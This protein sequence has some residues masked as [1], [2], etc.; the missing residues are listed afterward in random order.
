MCLNT[1]EFQHTKDDS[2][3]HSSICQGLE[4]VSTLLHPVQ[5]FNY[6]YLH[7]CT[8]RDSTSNQSHIL[9]P[10]TKTHRNHTK[11]S[12]IYINLSYRISILKC[13]VSRSNLTNYS[14]N[15]REYPTQQ[16]KLHT[17]FFIAFLSKYYIYIST[18]MTVKSSLCSMSTIV[19]KVSSKSNQLRALGKKPN[20][21]HVADHSY[22]SKLTSQNRPP[23]ERIHRKS[24]FCRK[25]FIV[26]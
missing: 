19:T 8:H 16:T 4:N 10:K 14:A 21:A 5:I 25:Q 6:C 17:R 15:S 13:F 24:L 18:Q 3:T 1:S 22:Y 11:K 2:H 20:R 12:R 26:I 23:E 7:Y 9:K